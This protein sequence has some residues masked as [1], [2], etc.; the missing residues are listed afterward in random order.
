MKNNE[1]T[2]REKLKTYF[3]LGDYP[4][5]SEFAE[6]IDSLRHKEDVL[7]YKEI[8]NFANRLETLDN[9]TIEFYVR[10]TG[11]LKF[12]IVIS[13]EDADDLIIEIDGKLGMTKRQKI[14]GKG[15][16]IITAKEFPTEVLETNEYYSLAYN[17]YDR[18]T[19]S[20]ELQ[21]LFGNNLPT[22]PDGFKIGIMEGEYFNLNILKYNIGEKIDVLNTGIQFINKT[23]V[24]IQ[25]KVGSGYWS[26]IYT[27]KDMITDHYSIADSLN[28]IFK[29]DLR[30][31]E[32]SI[33][34]KIF[35][36]HDEKL[37]MTVDL[38]PM[39]NN[40]QVSGAN[41]ADK[42]RDI[43]IECDYQ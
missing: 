26:S 2:T 5:Q 28:F 10:D 4:T 12:P 13:Q 9:K 14:F 30:K 16:F 20:S 22:I 24:D 19:G 36:T 40:F 1:V 15:A 27:N 35:S 39:E 43:R 6:L 42:I 29:A 18:T 23:Q 31:I 21:R 34:C 8:V 32:Q 41:S 11:D 17:S 3:Q 37:L 7:N 38:K 33:K 25:Y